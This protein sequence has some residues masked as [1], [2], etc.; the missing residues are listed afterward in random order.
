VTWTNTDSQAQH[1]IWLSF[2][3]FF[4]KPPDGSSIEVRTEDN[5]NHPAGT[6]RLARL[7]PLAKTTMIDLNEVLHP[8]GAT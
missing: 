4:L 3:D 6:L 5:P 2:R 1:L 7:S 8:K